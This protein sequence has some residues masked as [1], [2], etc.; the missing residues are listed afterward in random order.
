MIRIYQNLTALNVELTPEVRGVMDRMLASDQAIAEAEAARG[1]TAFFSEKPEGMSDE[2]WE[3]Y[4]QDRQLATE[5]AVATLQSASLRD[6]QWLTNAK[7]RVLKDLQKKHDALRREVR[8]QARS[9][10]MSQPVYRAW[11]WLK[12]PLDEAP[13]EEK[14]NKNVVDPTRDSLFVAIAKLGGIDRK[15]FLDSFGLSPEEVKGLRD[16]ST[17]RGVTRDR[18][19]RSLDGI[20]ETLAQEGYLDVDEHG[21]ADLRDLE[22][23]IDRELAGN[24]VYSS[25]V[26]GRYLDELQNGP[27][28]EMPDPEAPGGRLSTA[29]LKTMFGADQRWRKLTD[30]GMTRDAREATHPDA[31]AELFGFSSG[32]EL[33]EALINAEPPKQAIEGLTDQRMLQEH[34]ELVDPQARERAA[35]A[36]IHNELRTRVLARELNALSKATGSARLLAKAATEAARRTVGAIKIRDL[37]PS[38]YGVAEGKAGRAANEALKSG[39]TAKAASKKRAQLLNNTLARMAGQA[40]TDI[41]K[42]LAYLRKFSKASVRGK[43]EG[44]FLE[45][46]D[47]ILQLVDLRQ[48]PKGLSRSVTNLQQWA[49]GLRQ[50]GYEPQV[51]DWLMQLQQATHYK[52]LTVDQFRSMIDTIKSIEHVGR[53]TQKIRVEG[54]LVDMRAAVTELVDRMNERGEKFTTE[55]IVEPPRANVDGYWAVLAR[56]LGAMMRLVHGDILG[57]EFPVQQARPAR[58]RGAVPPLHPQPLARCQLPRQGRP[59]QDG[60]RRRG[61]VGRAARQGLAEEPLR[62][63]H[64]HH[65]HGPVHGQGAQDH[66]GDML[67]IARP[68]RQRV[69]LRQAGEGLRLE[70]GHRVGVPAGRT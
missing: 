26:D 27:V 34:G 70:A 60:E 7:A 23:K 14:P 68:R 28:H 50:I 19:G 1:M 13:P 37:K 35:E 54:K 42:G 12:G 45:Q 64:Q 51:A 6:M 61:Q 53:E 63:D 40:Q 57:Q 69:E 30:L 66:R 3:K 32:R 20:L 49:D 67:G 41:E 17:G 55:Q 11:Q 24:E 44:Q 58:G 65:A 56:K 16:P 33:V 47:N 59:H 15:E 31:V 10:V 8:A 52:E 9:D 38:Q 22:D 5:D 21:K 29:D 48:D 2:D 36:A 4:E 18:G 25:Q 46:I 39:D 62:P 43:I